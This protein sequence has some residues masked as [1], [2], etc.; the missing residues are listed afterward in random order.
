MS[1]SGAEKRIL[2]QK[3]WIE[4]DVEGGLILKECEKQGY[5]VTV[6]TGEQL[7]ELKGSD[8]FAADVYGAFCNTDIA[9]L[10]LPKDMVP[11]TYPAEFKHLYHRDIKACKAR[12][13]TSFPAFIKPRANNKD[14]SG[15][16][17]K[18]WADLP[19]PDTD[20]YCCPVVKMEKEYRLFLS[21]HGMCRNIPNEKLDDQGLPAFVF[22]VIMANSG[23]TQ[24]VDIAWMPD[25]RQW[26]VVE[27]NPAFG[28]GDNGCAIAEYVRF[29]VASFACAT[30]SF[31]RQNGH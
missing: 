6:K 21:Q 28:L 26:C 14:F 9:Q 11:D 20:I 2:L 29:T 10:F 31:L 23:R 7:R 3:E 8:F 25:Q 16:V 12:D 22:E 13:V 19:M 15:R 18:S 17:V 5:K 27:V 30:T 24:A 1:A 4:Y